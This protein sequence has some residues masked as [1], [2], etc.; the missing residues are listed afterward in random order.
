MKVGV[1]G[2]QG[3]GSWVDWSV[4]IATVSKYHFMSA[5]ISS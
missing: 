3:R 1:D 2:G 4:Y 5:F